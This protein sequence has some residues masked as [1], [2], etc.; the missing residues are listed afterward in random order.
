VAQLLESLQGM[1][2][3]IDD[4]LLARGR[5]FEFDGLSRSAAGRSADC[6]VFARPTPC[7]EVGFASLFHTALPLIKELAMDTEFLGQ[8][9]DLLTSEDP[10][11][12]LH[13][14]LAAIDAHFPHTR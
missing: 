13:A 1:L 12:D 3:K 7:T 5:P 4:Q 10:P 9:R 8:R 14:E 11:Y 6:V 2:E